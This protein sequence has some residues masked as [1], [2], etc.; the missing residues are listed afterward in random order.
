M[1][2]IIKEGQQKFN[3]FLI[4]DKIHFKSSCRISRWNNMLCFKAII[5]ETYFS[6]LNLKK[7]L[8]SYKYLNFD[9]FWH[10]FS[11]SEFSF[12]GLVKY[13]CLLSRVVAKL[14]YQNS[15]TFSCPV[16]HFHWPFKCKDSNYNLNVTLII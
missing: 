11:Y 7:L 1:F 14:Y 6:D 16:S 9:S 10:K 12:Q 15:I 2:P 13:Y 5:G 3:D 4:Y 8:R